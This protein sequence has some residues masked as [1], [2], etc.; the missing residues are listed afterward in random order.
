MVL[1]ITGCRIVNITNKHTFP[2]LDSKM[3]FLS[4]A[5]PIFAHQMALRCPTALRRKTYLIPIFTCLKR[6]RV[7]S[8]LFCFAL[9]AVCGR[10]KSP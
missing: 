6:E 2:L 4:I 3:N 7:F 5:V 8:G 9:P 1:S 10:K